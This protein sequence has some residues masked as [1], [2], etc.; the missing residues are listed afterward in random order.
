MLKANLQVGTSKN[1]KA[2]A[3]VVVSCDKYADLWDPFFHCLQKYWPDCPYKVYLVTNEKD[4]TDTAASVIKIGT[5]RSYS[6]NLRAAIAQIDEPWLILWL[7]DVF[8]S[9]PVDTGRLRQIVAKAQSIPVGYLKISPD[10]PLSYEGSE[11]DEIAPL[12]RGIRYRSAV[13][14]SLY[15]K[16]TLK[17]LLVPGASAWDL[18]T[19]RISDGLDEPFFALTPTAAL[20]PPI[21]WVHGVIKGR[22]CWPALG[23]L[24]REGFQKTLNGRET[25]RWTSV[26]YLMLFK[27]HNSF[28]RFFRRYWL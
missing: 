9:K 12:P 15:R 14:L 18:D 11:D 3:F 17:K 28:F 10:L 1:D 6:D 26:L 13:G 4:Y 23:F 16:D 27:L 2:V 24:K 7:E 5:D 25:Q 20:R 22:W 8:I 19:S 21:I